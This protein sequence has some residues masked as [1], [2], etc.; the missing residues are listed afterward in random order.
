MISTILLLYLEVSH[1]SEESMKILFWILFIID[2]I[3][4]FT[5]LVLTVSQITSFL[6]IRC[7]SL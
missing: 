6:G 7:F 5:F 4:V 1:T 2:I 3:W